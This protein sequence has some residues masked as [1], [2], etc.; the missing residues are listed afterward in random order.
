LLETWS[1]SFVLLFK[2]DKFTFAKRL[3]IK[4]HFKLPLPCDQL[5]I[6]IESVAPLTGNV[7]TFHKLPFDSCELG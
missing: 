4:Q 5:I 7:S 1:I 6:V 3:A 2:N